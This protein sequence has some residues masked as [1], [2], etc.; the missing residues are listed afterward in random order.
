MNILRVK[1]PKD[2]EQ[3]LIK[4]DLY[5]NILGTDSI[6][7]FMFDDST[8]TLIVEETNKI[9]GVVLLQHLKNNKVCLHAGLYKEFR[10]KKTSQYLKKVTKKLKKAL[11]PLHI[12][13]MVPEENTLASTAV[14]NAGYKFKYST[15][16]KNKTFFVYSE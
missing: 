14:L 6:A 5:K 7:E 15:V 12:I 10:N 4:D 9:I 16:I 11:F 1:Q 13:T 2:I 3:V 8:A